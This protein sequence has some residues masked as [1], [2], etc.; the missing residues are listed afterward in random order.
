MTFSEK[1]DEWISE[2]ET[3]PGSAL[4]ILKLVAGRLRDLT[5]RNEELLAE[6]IELENGSRVQEYQKQIAH[7]EFQ[8]EILKRRF[9]EGNNESQAGQDQPD[10]LQ[11]LVFNNDGRLLRLDPGA[12]SW[13]DLREAGQLTGQFASNGEYPRLLAL[14]ANEELLLLFSSGRVATRKMSEIASFEAGTSWEWEQISLPEAPHGA[15][16][17]VGIAPLSELAVSQFFMQTSRQGAVK[18][19]LCSISEK[20]L[21]NHYLGRGAVQKTD[22]AFE[23]SLAR[24]NERYAG[25]SREGRLQNLGVEG[26][27]FS[28]EER[29]KLT[30]TDHMVAAFIIHAGESLLALTQTGKV[31]VRDFASLETGKSSS[32][33]GQALI[34]AA[35]L[36]QGTRFIGA[37][38]CRP[39]DLLVTLD[40]DGRLAVHPVQEVTGAGAIQSE[41][42]FVGLGRIP[43]W[44]KKA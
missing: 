14:S 15:E 3:R 38:A 6:N 4:M 16:S 5:E 23:V 18:K 35:R 22:Q 8:L 10:S 20:I 32:A 1:I 34:S 7:L 30:A 27:S 9:G 31:V 13:M 40:E 25:L 41:K 37:A 36:E 42:N 29:L 21:S 44:E 43:V 19:T 17:L 26:L 24:K 2:A 11:L 39:Q 12:S 33:H 28:A